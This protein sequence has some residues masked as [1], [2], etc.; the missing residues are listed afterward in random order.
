VRA[1]EEGFLYVVDR[2]KDMIISGGENIYCAE[3]E[4]V[5]SAHSSSR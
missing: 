2:K 1:D 4:Y 5:L 3:V